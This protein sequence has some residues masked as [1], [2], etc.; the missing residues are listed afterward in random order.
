MNES[1]PTWISLVKTWLSQ[2][3]RE[4]VISHVNESTLSTP[5]TMTAICGHV[6]HKNQ[7]CYTYEWV[8]SHRWLI[9]GTHTNKSWELFICYKY[10]GIMSQIWM[11]QSQHM[12][13]PCHTHESVMS[14]LFLHECSGHLRHKCVCLCAYAHICV[15]S[16]KFFAKHIGFCVL[17]QGSV[18]QLL[19]VYP[20][21]LCNWYA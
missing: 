1:C 3:T 2:V 19:N 4:W 21:T 9:Q 11:S 6:T 5:V 17:L 16:Q 13:E 18:Y 12:S 14:H 20:C 8:K 10:E 7:S 15:C